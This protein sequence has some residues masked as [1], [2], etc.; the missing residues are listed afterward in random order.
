MQEEIIDDILV[1]R[2]I[3]D[4][5]NY[6]CNKCQTITLYRIILA[7]SLLLHQRALSLK[8]S[9]PI[10]ISISS[11]FLYTVRKEIQDNNK[12]RIIMQL[13]MKLNSIIPYII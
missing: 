7:Y 6:K 2:H 8:A 13:I 4:H 3:S 10:F 12:L 1:I 11:T 5:I 9:E